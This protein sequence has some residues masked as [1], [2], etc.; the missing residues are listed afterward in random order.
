MIAVAKRMHKISEY[1][2][3]KKIQEIQELEKKGIVVINLGIGNPDLS[4]PNGV[5]QKMK[6]ASERS[7][8]NSYQSYIGIDPLRQAIAQWY[9]HMYQV[10]IDPQKEILPLMG[11]KE[12]IMQISMSYLE[13]GDQVLIPNPGYPSYSSISHLL[14]AE[15]IYYNLDEKTHWI[16]NLKALESINLSKVK[17]MWLNYPHMPTGAVISWKELKKIVHFAIKKRILLVYDNPY[18][19]ILNKTRY[20]SIFNIKEAK[21]I[22]LE[23]NSLSKSYNMPGWRIGMVIGK[24][25]FIKNILKAKS[26]MDSG[27]YY[28]IQM[29]AIEAMNHRIAW[30]RTLNKEYEKRRKIIWKICDYLSLDY[31][32]ECSGIFVWAKLKGPS[33]NE[34]KWSEEFFKKYHIFITPGRIFGDN[35]KGYVRFSI[36]C[37]INILYQAKK[38]IIS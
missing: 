8:A 21:E 36:C 23:L 33:K 11:S 17:I 30:F 31:S 13:K 2:F 9:H 25:K 26:Q 4:P 35:G 20:L 10:C 16:P 14:G 37:P 34:E 19:F 6:E 22:A 38:R 3:S 5:I 24:H 29:G 7:Y 12:G 1:F 15:I 18:S 27:M 32:K 28:P